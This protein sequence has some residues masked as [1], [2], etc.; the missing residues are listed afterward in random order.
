MLLF[1]FGR[2]ADQNTVLYI[3]KVYIAQAAEAA[4]WRG[5]LRPTQPI[6]RCVHWSTNDNNKISQLMVFITA[7]SRDT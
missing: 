5:V 3:V 4:R 2:V 6:K 1:G 7:K